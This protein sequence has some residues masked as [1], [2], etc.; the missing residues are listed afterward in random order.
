MGAAGRGRVL[1]RWLD[2][3]LDNERR[4][5]GLLQAETGKSS[6][7]AAIETTVAVDLINY[8][9]RI[10]AGVY[11]RRFPCLQQLV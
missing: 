11:L 1:L 5:P 3:I 4:L 7:D 8:Y 2:W 10:Q 9:W 6:G